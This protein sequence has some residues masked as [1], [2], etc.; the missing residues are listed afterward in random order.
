[1]DHALDESPHQLMDPAPFRRAN[2]VC[3]ECDLEMQPFSGQEADGSYSSGWAC[4][5]CGWSID[6][7]GDGPF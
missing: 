2:P 4:G 6:E 5:G 1:M 7:G 3:K